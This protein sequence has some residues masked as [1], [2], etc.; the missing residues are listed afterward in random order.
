MKSER[1]PRLS[2]ALLLLLHALA[3]SFAGMRS[4]DALG[5][6]TGAGEPRTVPLVLSTLLLAVAM[7]G[8]LAAALGLLRSRPFV[9]GWRPV[10]LVALGASALFLTA[11]RPPG[12]L[13]GFAGD[14][15]L[16]VLVLRLPALLVVRRAPRRWRRAAR[17]AFEA[18]AALVIAWTAAAVL[19]RPWHT[20]WGSTTAELLMILPGDERGAVY[21]H[22]GMQHAVTIDAPPREVWPWLAQ[23][24][25]DR[26]G[27]YSHATLENLFGIG[28]V[29][30][31]RIHPEWQDVAERGFVRATPEGWMGLDRE[32]GWKVPVARADT[33]L[34]LDAWGAFVLLPE[35]EGRTRFIIR[36]R[37]S[38]EPSWRATVFAP[39]GLLAF[40]PAHYI[41]QR[42]MMLGIKE[43][44]EGT[45]GAEGTGS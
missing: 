25:T 10:A 23:L 6:V 36:T 13:T 3:H 16:A 42:E 35:E 28:V 12:W 30:A 45:E 34:Y 9:R 22:Y 39:I 26:G 5:G 14:L 38:G 1:L 32:L 18:A 21:P 2:L 41:M 31:D 4:L 17:L 33:L 20:R 44:A 7:A 8:G 27:F 43:R 37:G 11:N 40:E 24:G 29:N 19:A 15:A